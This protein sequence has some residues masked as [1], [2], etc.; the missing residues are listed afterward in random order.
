MFQTVSPFAAKYNL[1]VTSEFD[2]KD[3]KGAA[4]DV[5]KKKG[6]VLMV[7]NHSEI[8]N[9]A[10][11]LGVEQELNWKENDFDSILVIS[12]SSGSPIL[13]HDNQG[14]TPGADCTF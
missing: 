3:S 9:L 6:T 7:W 1:K 5:L 4:S 8:P 2:E 14:I 13:R 11:A 12:F 10:K